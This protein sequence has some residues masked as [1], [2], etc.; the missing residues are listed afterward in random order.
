MSG[1]IVTMY[2]VAAFLAFRS[3][4]ELMRKH[5]IRHQYDLISK[6]HK[7]AEEAEAAKEAAEAAEKK[8]AEA[9]ANKAA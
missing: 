1:W 8:E 4:M 2:A 5:Q 6:V 3:L 7:E 9:N